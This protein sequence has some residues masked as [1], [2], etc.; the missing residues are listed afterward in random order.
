M[1][2]SCITS[3]FYYFTADKNDSYKD[4]SQQKDILGFTWV[5]TALVQS[6]QEMP[7]IKTGFNYDRSEGIT[8]PDNIIKY[9]SGVLAA[10]LIDL[11]RVLIIHI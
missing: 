3:C 7:N 11:R 4:L 9:I 2:I 10:L 1:T 5:V 6:C 8:L